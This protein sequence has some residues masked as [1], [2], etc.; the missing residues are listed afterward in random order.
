MDWTIFS[1]MLVYHSV[2]QKG[3]TGKSLTS[4]HKI[5]RCPYLNGLPFFVVA[6]KGMR[7]EPPKY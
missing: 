3:A 2:A 6:E 4:L 1:V 5:G 7:F